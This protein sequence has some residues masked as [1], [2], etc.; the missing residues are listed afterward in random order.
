MTS[1]AFAES[2]RLVLA[3]GQNQ[4][5]QSEVPLRYAHADARGY[6]RLLQ[7]QGG[8]APRHTIVLTETT[9]KGLDEGF[10]RIRELAEKAAGDVVFFFYYSGHGDSQ[11][12]HLGTSRYQLRTLNRALESVNAKLRIAVVDACRSLDDT[13]AKGFAASA[14]FD[15]KMG[16]P[17]GIEGV[18]T[19]RSSA[20]G[21]ASQES[22]QLGGAV[23]THFFMTALRG[24]ADR[25]QDLRV[26]LSEAYGYAYDQTIKRSAASTANVM[27][28]SVEIDVEGAGR[29]MLTD[30]LPTSSK[31]KLPREK[32]ARYLIYKRPTGVLVNESWSDSDTR[33]VVPLAAGEY[34]VQRRKRGSSG[35]LVIRIEPGQTRTLNAAAF[36][37]VPDDLLSLK[38]GRL[39][40]IEGA[41]SL[42]YT[43]S[44]EAAGELAH[45]GQLRYSI[46][47]VTWA[48]SASLELGRQTYE[49]R[50]DNRTERWIGGDIRGVW[51]RFLGPMDIFAGVVWRTVFQRIENKTSPLARAAGYTASADYTGAAG[52]PT[53]GLTWRASIG[54]SGFIGV[55][56]QSTVLVL[57][58]GRDTTYRPTFGGGFIFGWT[59]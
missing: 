24:A 27:H 42:A 49:T 39:K 55:E 43:P 10:R 44:I 5:L 59:H 16:A 3:V 36:R 23:F 14:P 4:G 35:A 33:A 22:T 38:G 12:L 26:S 45:R 1:P 50:N 32:H 54:P 28:P 47:P 40:L 2:T 8:V 52:G 9:P 41:L 34:L 30:V 51:R 31:L 19:I 6:V 17:K 21:E 18:V 15:M 13:Q 29:V 53:G 20:E 25:D 46:G 56:A 11:S 58:E 48:L 37:A 57:Q 7:S